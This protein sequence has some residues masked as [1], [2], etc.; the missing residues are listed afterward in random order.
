M[1][2]NISFIG[3][4]MVSKWFRVEIY[5]IYFEEQKGL[6]IKVGE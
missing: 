5:L 1:Q 4:K 6:F 2:A 3:K